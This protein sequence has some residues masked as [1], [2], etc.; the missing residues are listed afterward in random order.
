MATK[1]LPTPSVNNIV[2]FDPSMD[3]TINFTYLGEEIVKNQVVIIDNETSN[4]VYNEEYL[5]GKT[6]HLLL[7]KNLNNKVFAGKQYLI[8]LKVFN[9][10]GD[11]SEF[12][13]PVL[14][15]CFTKPT[16]EFINISDND[17]K[18]SDITLNLKYEQLEGEEIKSFQF[19]KYSID[20]ILLESSKVYYS[21]S[22]LSHIFYGLDNNTTYIFKAVCETKHGIICE[23]TVQ[24]TVLLDNLPSSVAIDINNHYKDGYISLRLNLKIIEYELGN[25]DYELK[26]GV[27]IIKN[28][29][30]LYKGFSINEDFS[31]FIEAFELPIGQFFT[32]NDNI[33]SLSILNV[34]NVYYCELKINNSNYVQY[35]P[36]DNIVTTTDGYIKVIDKD[37]DKDILI[38]VV[39]KRINNYY[40]LEIYYKPKD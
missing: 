25:D 40:A 5:S 17:Y 3:Y 14:F 20:N 39:V 30:L 9:L 36:L 7:T 16:F 8:K 22:V 33:F 4:E 24:I 28:N 32:T 13:S 34:C 27:L 38:G 2:P 26:D 19:F 6:E 10:D 21:T 11:E 37:I 1:I 12:S 29:S 31:L 35:I 18:G 23:D 15:Y